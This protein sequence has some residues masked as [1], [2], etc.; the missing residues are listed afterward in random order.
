MADLSAFFGEDEEEDYYLYEDEGGEEVDGNLDNLN[1]SNGGEEKDC[2]IEAE[3][4]INEEL[5][6]A[7]NTPIPNNN[8]GTNGELKII[9]ENY[10]KEQEE[11]LNYTPLIFLGKYAEDMEFESFDDT[12]SIEYLTKSLHSK[13][14]PRKIWA[15]ENMTSILKQNP[16]L[17]GFKSV[18]S[19]SHHCLNNGDFDL[20]ASLTQK[21]DELLLFI[22]KEI[23][24][25]LS[26]ALLSNSYSALHTRDICFSKLDNFFNN[27][28]SEAIHRFFS[29]ILKIVEKIENEEEGFRK[30][31]LSDCMKI[32]S[33]TVRF[34]SIETIND[35]LVPV[36]SKYS[37]Y[38]QYE[39]RKESILCLCHLIQLRFT[40][41]D[42]DLMIRLFDNLVADN[43]H[44]VRQEACINFKHIADTL[45]TQN[46]ESDLIKWTDM[47]F[48]DTSSKV[49]T[50]A[51]D[52]I[53]PIIY[54]FRDKEVPASLM[55]K[56]VEMPN[57]PKPEFRL[58]CAK[59]FPGVLLA[60]GSNG[61]DELKEIFI[62]LSS[63]SFCE[64]R[65]VIASFLHELSSIISSEAMTIDVV[66]VI[67][68]YLK[69][70]NQHTIFTIASNASKLISGLDPSIQQDILTQ[71]CERL[72]HEFEISHPVKEDHYSVKNIRNNATIIEYIK[73]LLPI[74]SY[75]M[76]YDMFSIE[77]ISGFKYQT[78]EFRLNMVKLYTPITTRLLEI[79]PSG[80]ELSKFFNSTIFHNIDKLAEDYKTRQFIIMISYE[81]IQAS[82]SKLDIHQDIISNLVELSKFKDSGTQFNIIRF[83]KQI[84]KLEGF[85]KLSTVKEF[86]NLYTELKSTE[87]PQIIDKL[88]K[89]ATIPF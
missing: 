65:Y 23:I 54:A 17:E 38:Q 19:L 42:S 58:N 56:Y 51:Q 55:E 22:Y 1:I 89:V 75:K 16:W 86:N 5:S 45:V 21:I 87:D 4:D 66:P 12:R 35:D 77:N 34:L 31:M 2:P 71:L 11:E 69:E 52:A 73:S 7:I 63:D 28:S 50:S 14:S 30:S 68:R 80:S 62:Q 40:E 18:F 78:S 41:V 82:P 43:N 39:T 24:L 46:R 79:E 49:K 53:G 15:A 8:S 61:W 83:L 85:A 88:P 32:M 33:K 9:T 57:S 67:H 59:N 74:M 76:I 84:S 36:L 72:S 70:H 6:L 48:D 3:V 29:N 44:E 10:S 25:V 26:N 20:S 81:V 13:I 47:L 37:S 64:V 60:L 27:A